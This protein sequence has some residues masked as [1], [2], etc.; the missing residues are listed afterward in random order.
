[1]SL[2]RAR[3]LSLTVFSPTLAVPGDLLNATPF[4]QDYID[5][6]DLKTEDEDERDDDDDDD[7]KSQSNHLYGIAIVKL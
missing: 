5:A 6:D 7:G 2:L 3:S 1:M 4:L